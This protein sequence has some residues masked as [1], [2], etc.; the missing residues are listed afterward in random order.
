MQAIPVSQLG[1]LATILMAED[2]DDHALLART[3][4]E[5]ARLQVDLHVVEDG[6]QCMQF[7]RRQGPFVDAPRPDLLLLDIHMP[8][9][10]GYG[11]MQAIL[12]D[13]NLRALPVVALT[14]SAD[15]LDVRRMYELRCNSYVIK[16]VSF[17]GLVGVVR[18]IQDFW[19]SLVVLPAG[20]SGR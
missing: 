4:F 17:D 12:E 3:A 11:V 2:N 8:R 6:I 19:L 9:L 15:V 14:T 7:L 16:P 5:E 20:P 10:D 1:R 13:P 18:G